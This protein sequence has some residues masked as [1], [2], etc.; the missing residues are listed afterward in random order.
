MTEAL[1]FLS[2]CWSDAPSLPARRATGRNSPN[3]HS[4]MAQCA[5]SPCATR[6]WQK[7]ASNLQN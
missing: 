6:R 5:T 3:N 1:P 7:P 4:I 2:T